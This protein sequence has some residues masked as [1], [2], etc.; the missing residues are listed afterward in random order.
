MPQISQIKEKEVWFRFTP[1]GP[2][3]ALQI[4]FSF[5]CVICEICGY[6]ISETIRTFFSSFYPFHP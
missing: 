1:G 5:I 2:L 4:F 6:L 3:D